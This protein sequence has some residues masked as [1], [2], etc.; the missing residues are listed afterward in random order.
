M[1]VNF[2]EKAVPVIR[3]NPDYYSDHTNQHGNRDQRIH[4]NKP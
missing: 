2:Q 1:I 4:Q 3:P